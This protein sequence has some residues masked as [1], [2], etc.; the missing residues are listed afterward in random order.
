MNKLDTFNKDKFKCEKCKEYYD[1]FYISFKGYSHSLCETCYKKWMGM[2]PLS[3]R[4]A[5]GFED[6]CK[7]EQ[8]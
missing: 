4:S 6:W 1:S 5:F 8:T 3:S 7:D 2:P